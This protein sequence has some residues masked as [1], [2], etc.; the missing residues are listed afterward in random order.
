MRM[1]NR[2]SCCND[3]GLISAIVQFYVCKQAIA[4]SKP[5]PL[6]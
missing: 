4:E 3:V 1:D 5:R 6:R 2:Y